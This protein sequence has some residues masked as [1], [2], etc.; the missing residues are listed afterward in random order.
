E[1]E[2]FQWIDGG[3]VENSVLS[4]LRR[5]RSNDDCTVIVCNFTP[6]VR[7]GYRVG[8]PFAGI[9]HECIN[10]DASEYGG[11]GVGNGGAVESAPVPAHGHS[12]SLGL[13][14]PPLAALIFACPAQRWNPGETHDQD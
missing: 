6:V 13:T 4:F 9:Y 2:G 10:T 8:V 3:D 1:P 7:S 5:G 11:S 12:H 14:L